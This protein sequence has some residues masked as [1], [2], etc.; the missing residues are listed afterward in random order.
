MS[1]NHPNQTRVQIRT[2][3]EQKIFLENAAHRCGFKNLS[4]FM[5]VSAYEKAKR[6]LKEFPDIKQSTTQLSEAD[7]KIIVNSFL[8]AAEPNELL[9]SLFSKDNETIFKELLNNDSRNLSENE[10]K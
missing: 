8:N 3:L 9:K 6:D 5:R 7:S 2:T 1:A 4:E 10:S